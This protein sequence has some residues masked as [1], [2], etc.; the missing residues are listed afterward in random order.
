MTLS[1]VGFYGAWSIDVFAN[2]ETVHNNHHHHPVRINV[3]LELSLQV[4]MLE[5]FPFNITLR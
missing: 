3:K 1:K 5:R 2:L 4:K